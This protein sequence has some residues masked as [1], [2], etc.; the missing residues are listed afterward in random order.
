[1]KSESFKLIVVDLRSS[2]SALSAFTPFES[3]T[4]ETDPG[5]VYPA[6][7]DSKRMG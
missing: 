3:S 1:M 7:S 5:F 6:V 2:R 4:T